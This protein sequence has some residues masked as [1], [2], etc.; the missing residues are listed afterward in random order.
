MQLAKSHGAEVTA[1]VATRHLDLVKSLGA[2]HAVDYTAEDFT[3]IGETFDCI[4]VLY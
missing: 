3:Q 2:D 1:A 4:I